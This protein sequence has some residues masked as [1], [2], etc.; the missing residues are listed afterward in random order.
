MFELS[1]LHRVDFSSFL[2]EGGWQQ[3]IEAW[4]RDLRKR[5]RKEKKQAEWRDEGKRRM[6]DR[7]SES[8]LSEYNTTAA[9]NDCRMHEKHALQI[10][11]NKANDWIISFEI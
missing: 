7:L 1:N 3:D 4:K 5:E 10:T 8:E 9:K 2:A 6:K 11:A